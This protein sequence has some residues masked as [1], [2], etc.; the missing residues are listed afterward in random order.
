MQCQSLVSQP[1]ARPFAQADKVGD[2]F[3]SYVLTQLD[4][5]PAD[6]TAVEC[7]VQ[8]ALRVSHCSSQLLTAS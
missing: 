7:D 4:N 8:E 3:W 2:G 6:R 5:D 1:I